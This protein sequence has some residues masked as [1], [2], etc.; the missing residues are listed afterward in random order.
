MNRTGDEMKNL[1]G[2]RGALLVA[3]SYGAFML[4]LQFIEGDGPHVFGSAAANSGDVK[5]AGKRWAAGVGLR[6]VDGEQVFASAAIS[7]SGQR[8]RESLF[9]PARIESP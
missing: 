6:N 3:V 1:L 7:I 2:K 5:I 9:L 4:Y 8:G